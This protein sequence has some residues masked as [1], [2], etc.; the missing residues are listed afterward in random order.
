ME[1][2]VRSARIPCTPHGFRTLL[3]CPFSRNADNLHCGTRLGARCYGDVAGHRLELSATPPFI[4]KRPSPVPFFHRPSP[5]GSSDLHHVLTAPCV[6]ALS[7]IL[8]CTFLSS[9]SS[10]CLPLLAF[11]SPP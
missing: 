7:D 3:H 2:K 4:K 5:R 1:G 11:S 9:P 6:N 8:K 10:P